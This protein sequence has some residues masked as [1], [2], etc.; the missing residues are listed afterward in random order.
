MNKM[1]LLVDPQCDF[2]N[3][4]LPVPGA[5]AAMDALA[6]WLRQNP[7]QYVLKLAT[8]DSHPWNHR[9][10]AGEGGKWPRHCVRHSLGAAIWPSIMEALYE[11]SGD[12]IIMPKGQ[13]RE[14]EEYSIFNN[15]A[16]AEKILTLADE[17]QI[18]RIDICGL[19]GDVCVLAT[20]D[21]ACSLLGAGRLNV[22]QQFSP[23]LDGG[24][25]LA[26]YCRSMA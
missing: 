4:A 6:A 7:E 3:G 26:E 19:A 24:N 2:I 20:L 15:P 12:A 9:S 14:I 21:S 23:S 11:T 18:D 16:N 25:A 8:C 22:L 13:N 5:Q 17:Y 10:F 1:L